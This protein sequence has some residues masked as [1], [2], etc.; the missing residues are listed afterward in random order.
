MYETFRTTHKKQMSG[1]Q[2]A[3]RDEE[4]LMGSWFPRRVMDS[5]GSGEWWRQTKHY[6]GIKCHSW[7]HV[8]HVYVLPQ[9]KKDPDGETLHITDPRMISD[10]AR[11]P[12][13]SPGIAQN[14]IITRTTTT[15]KWGYNDS[16]VE[17]VSVLHAAHQ[18]W[19]LASY[20]VPQDCQE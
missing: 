9:F 6:E 11:G 15:I 1:C 20:T 8:H 4:W 12:W 5:F 16:T 3:G 19:I 2:S 7:S 17:R 10:I 13:A 18:V 14:L